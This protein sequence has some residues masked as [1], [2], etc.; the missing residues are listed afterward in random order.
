MLRHDAKTKLHN[1]DRPQLVHRV[2]F[3]RPSRRQAIPI[4]TGWRNKQP[5]LRTTNH[6]IQNRNLS[7]R[8]NF[9]WI[10]HY[11]HQ[12]INE[13]VPAFALKLDC[14]R[15]Y[16]SWS[17]MESGTLHSK[18]W[19]CFAI[20]PKM[21]PQQS[22]CQQSEILHIGIGEMHPSRCASNRH[23]LRFFIRSACTFRC[24]SF[25]TVSQWD[26]TGIPSYWIQKPDWHG[27]RLRL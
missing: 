24:C 1:A 12:G 5:W 27:L 20:I 25:V 18:R 21:E 17:Q 13:K 23:Q 15:L 11:S 10:N 16:Q 8:A 6:L 3:L 2:P 4:S 9:N 19:I 26:W 14:W 7:R 22:G